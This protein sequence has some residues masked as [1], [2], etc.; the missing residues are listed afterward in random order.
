MK[1][2]VTGAAGFIGSH[3]VLEL[4]KAG[5]EV[6]CIDNFANSIPGWFFFL[7]FTK[8]AC[9]TSVNTFSNKKY[10]SDTNGNAVSLQR[11]AQLTGK[12]IPF[13]QCDVCD[14]EQLDSIFA[15]VL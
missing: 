5:H 15:K 1:V 13:Q 6:V 8:K 2:L 11:V 9:E 12:T 4:L 7:K 3:T 10:S 14:M